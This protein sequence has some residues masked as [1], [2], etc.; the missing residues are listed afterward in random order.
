MQDRFE[1]FIKETTAIYRAVQQIKNME[2]TELGLKGMHVMCV[3]FL[4]KHPDGLTAAQLSEMCGE[5]KASI[6][7]TVTTLKEK[8]YITEDQA[9]FPKKYRSVISLT[10]SGQALGKIEHEKI[11]KV[12]QAGG[13]GLAE[14]NR[15]GFYSSLCLIAENLRQYAAEIK[16]RG[17]RQ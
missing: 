15:A 14:Q 2:M 8:G 6:S 10:E 5:D 12:F 9:D 16:N 4:Y 11:V 7:R 17:D 13:Q 1:T 3:Y